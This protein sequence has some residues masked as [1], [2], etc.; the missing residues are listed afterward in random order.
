M[1]ERISLAELCREAGYWSQ[2]S[3]DNPIVSITPTRWDH[4]RRKFMG[5]GQ[6]GLAQKKSKVSKADVAI[7]TIP[8]FYATEDSIKNPEPK[9]KTAK[10]QQSNR[11]VLNDPEALAAGQPIS[12]AQR[13]PYLEGDQ[14]HA[15]SMGSAHRLLQRWASTD[16][17]R[18]GGER[19][20]TIYAGRRYS[21]FVDTPRGAR[22][23]RSC[24]SLIKTVRVNGM[25]HYDY[26]DH[27]PRCIVAADTIE[28]FRV[29]CPGM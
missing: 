17:Q 9:Q 13:H 7:A 24:Y 1:T 25:E 20:R 29:C 26:L 5:A 22:A 10:R 16:P 4:A 23:R 28:N 19:H 11:P 12:G 2:A 3:R 14:L 6:A 18:P 15:H 21:S 8:N 27:V